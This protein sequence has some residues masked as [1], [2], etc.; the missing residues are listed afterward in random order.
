VL[1]L[2][3]AI[4]LVDT[5]FFAALT[6]LLP[7]YAHEL[8]LGKAG[9]GLL[10]AAYPLGTLV[11]AIPSG[12]V[13]ARF[14]VKRTVLV[15]LGGVAVTTALFGIAE[16]AAQLD[17]ARFLQGVA[18]SFSWTG[19]LAW[20][21]AS[22]PEGAKGRLIGQAFA[23]AV[24]GALLGPVLGGV[25]TITGPGWTFGAVAVASLGLAAWAWFT[26]ASRPT[27]PQPLDML[28]AAVRD[29]RVLLSIWF[30]VLPALLFG[31]LGVLGPL[32]LSALGVGAIGIGAVWLAAGLLESV[33]NLAVGRLSDRFGPLA[34]IRVAL[35]ATIAATLVLPWPEN[36]Y[37]LALAIVVAALAFGTFYTPGMAMLTQAA[38]SR[39]LDYGY[40]FALLNL[41]WAPGQSLGSVLGGAAAEASSDAV[42]VA[43]PRDRP[44]TAPV[45][46]VRASGITRRVLGAADVAL[47]RTCAGSSAS[48]RR[49]ERWLCAGWDRLPWARTPGR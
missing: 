34:P 17:L 14:G 5:L 25:A 26:P 35:V 39:G 43:R 44:D 11:G 21:V 15:G 36:R 12:M 16:T 18:S 1:Y 22:A 45:R 28:G 8:G 13:A 48:G 19:A 46:R 24:A 3:S 27:E 33:N 41:A 23:A 49:V 38:E 2:A 32:R 37:I 7:H 20:L 30:V 10:S 29:R 47:A 40:A 42:P 9:A 6:P 31:V 4:V